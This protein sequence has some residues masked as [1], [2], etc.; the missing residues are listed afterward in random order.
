MGQI[1]DVHMIVMHMIGYYFMDA[2][3]A[4]GPGAAPH[5]ISGAA[6]G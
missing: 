1:E 2:E 3:N 4:A 5:K 6:N